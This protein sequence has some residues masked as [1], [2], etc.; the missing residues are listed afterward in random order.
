MGIHQNFK[1]A[2]K[3]THCGCVFIGAPRVSSPSKLDDIVD[4]IFH[5][6]SII[7]LSSYYSPTIISYPHDMLF[8]NPQCFLVNLINLNHNSLMS[9]WPFQEPKLEVP[10]IYKAYVRPM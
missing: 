5:Y 4:H 9:Q 8:M 7:L 10:T 2:Q 1:P 6:F 3:T